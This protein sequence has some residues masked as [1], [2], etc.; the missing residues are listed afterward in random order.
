MIRK[1]H[2]FTLELSVDYA[3]KS[4]DVVQPRDLSDELGDACNEI[5]NR[6]AS[7]YGFSIRP[8]SLEIFFFMVF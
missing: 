5:V 1:Y 6:T 4:S 2:A 3:S 7:A 8:W